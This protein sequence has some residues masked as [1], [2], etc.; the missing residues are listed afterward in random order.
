MPSDEVR[1]PE[2]TAIGTLTDQDIVVERC[3]GRRSALVAVGTLA[4]SALAASVLG[5]SHTARAK[6]PDPPPPVREP[7]GGRSSAPV[8]DMDP[9]DSLCRLPPPGSV[10][11]DSDPSDPA[12]H[13]R[14]R[15]RR[16]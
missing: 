10:H 11:T 3:V 4:A 7:E 15:R 14:G 2:S 13:G 1:P 12:G 5:A 6:P 9:N 16:H 8:E